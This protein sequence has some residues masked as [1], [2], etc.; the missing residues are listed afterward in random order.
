MIDDLIEKLIELEKKADG[1]D[2]SVYVQ[3][4]NLDGSKDVYEFDDLAFDRDKRN[5]SALF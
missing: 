4:N 3:V 5:E 2:T 1:G